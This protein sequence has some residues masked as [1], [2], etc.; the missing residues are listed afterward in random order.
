MNTNK[1]KDRFTTFWKNIILR[2]IVLAVLSVFGLLLFSS[3]FLDL[4]TRHGSSAPVPDFIGKSMDS[5]RIIAQRHKLRIE[6]VD[7]VFRIGFPKG[8]VFLQN[9]EAGIHVKKNRKIFVTI[10]SF[11][12]RKEPVPNVKEISLR[13]A[14]T[15]LNAKGFRVGKLEYSTRYNRFTNHVFQQFYKGK[16]IEPGVL[17]PVGEYIDLK[18][19]LDSTARSTFTIPDVTGLQKQAVE[20]LIVENSLNYILSFEGK[21]LKTIVDT[22]NAEAYKQEPAAGSSSYYGNNVRVW[23][24][25]PDKPKKK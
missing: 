6:I 15:D 1:Y 25:L 16:E 23:L 3:I 8:S 24:K 21:G 11:S 7:S 12:P 20:D 4:F 14:K 19:G 10:N 17:L 5:V 2:N 18:L 9:P 22:L 13:R